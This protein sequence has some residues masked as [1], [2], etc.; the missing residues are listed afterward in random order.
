[1]LRV[2]RSILGGGRGESGPKVP[3]LLCCERLTLS[4]WKDGSENPEEQLVTGVEIELFAKDN[5]FDEV[6][7]VESWVR[8]LDLCWS[9][10]KV[11]TQKWKS[12]P[13]GTLDT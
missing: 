1:M 13:F 11:F 9:M 7:P 12:L 6:E 3:P 4:Y 2:G 10:K 8:S 5:D